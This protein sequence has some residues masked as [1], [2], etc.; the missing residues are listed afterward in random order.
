MTAPAVTISGPLASVQFDRFDLDAYQM[1]LATK[2]LPESQVE[3]DPATETY[4]VTTPARFA[5][6][7]G[8]AV[9]ASERPGLPLA[10]HLFDYQ[11]FVVERA[12]AARRF[13][14]WADT[15][16]GKTTI[17]LEYIRQVIARTAGRPVQSRWRVGLEGDHRWP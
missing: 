15:G 3:F 7:L 14:C 2:R 4:R 13:A 1:F 9:D 5:P 11:Q 12:L 17:A 10:G 8:A 16:L 6:L